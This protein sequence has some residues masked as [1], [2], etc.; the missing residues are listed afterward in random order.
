VLELGIALS[1]LAGG[2]LLWWFVQRRDRAQS[3]VGG[4]ELG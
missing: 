1:F 2:V 4:A 3:A